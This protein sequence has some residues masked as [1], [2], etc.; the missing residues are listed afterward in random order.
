MLSR[1]ATKISLTLDDIYDYERRKAARDSMRADHMNS[2]EDT[3]NS[4][5][6]DGETR[7]AKS[8]AAREQRILGGPSRG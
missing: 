1:P 2:S 3:S 4:A 8:K 7:A 6:D 5:V